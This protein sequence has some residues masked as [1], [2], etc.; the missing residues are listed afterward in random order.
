MDELLDLI[1]VGT[2][3]VLGYSGTEEIEAD[4][5]FQE[6]G[7]GSLTA[8]ELRNRLSRSTGLELPSTL[9]FDYPT[10]EAVARYL[11]TLL[12]GEEEDPVRSQAPIAAVDDDPV[13]IVGLACRFPGGVRSPADLWDLVVSGTDAVSGFPVGRGWDAEALYD[14]DPDRPGT[15]YVRGGGFLHDADGFDAEFFGISPRE[16]LAMDP[17]QRLL[18]E[19]SWESLE[20]TGIDPTSLKGTRTG[21]FTG[22]AAFDYPSIVQAV[23]E[24]DGHSLT[25][26]HASVASGRVAYTLGLEGPALTVDTACS[27]SLVALHLAAESLRRGECSLALAGGATVLSGPSVYLGFSRQRG[28]SPDGRCRAF[29]DSADG[30]GPAEG[31]GVLVLER[32]SDARRHGHRVWAVV[33]GSAVNQDGA[34]NGLTAPNGP[35]QQRVIREALAAA[36]LSTDDVDLVEAHGTGTP[37]GDPIE[38]QALLATYG[39]RPSGRA[40]LLLGSVKSNIGHTQAAAG[41]AGVIKAVLALHHGTVPPT[42]HVDRPSSHVDWSAGAVRLA[43][44]AVPW[45]ELDRPRRAAVSSFG[46]SGTNGHVILE[47]PAPEA[48]AGAPDGSSAVTLPWVLSGRTPGALREQAARL[49]AYAEA[50]PD[51][52]PARI[53]AALAH[54]R[55]A[56]E[57]RAAVLVHSHQDAVSG[58]SALAAG[59]PADHTVTGTALRKPA[60]VLVFPGQ[61]SQWTGMGRELLASSPVFADWITQCETAFAPYVDWSLTPVLRGDDDAASLE[62]VDVVQPALFAVL[63]G[64]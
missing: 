22:L 50:H 6:L 11:R 23:P 17:Q 39:Q 1:R 49:C 24:L 35:S 4:C 60:P 25:G 32:L 63:T 9:V 14:P 64:I 40:P 42:L 53:A 31:V 62:R 27:S 29:A 56:F 54:G 7:V 13:V 15:L 8:Q 38:A 3:E 44:E 55:T 45:P 21:V 47:A 34:S 57:H 61:G 48:K 10:P 26:T 59:E 51:A 2:A 52:D 16:A 18:L 58:L 46:M 12:T 20:H 37:L 30:F 19:V 41:V 5:T 33:R 36:G 43:T 28:L